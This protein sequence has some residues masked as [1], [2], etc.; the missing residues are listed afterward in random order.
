MADYAAGFGMGVLAGL[1]AAAITGASVED[2]FS[3]PEALALAWVIAWPIGSIVGV[4][5]VAR[6]RTG[7][8]L[9]WA[10]L[11][12]VVG[13]GVL[14]LPFWLRSDSETLRAVCGIAALLLAPA[15]ARWGIDIQR[16][17]TRERFTER[18]IESPA[19]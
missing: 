7:A 12:T 19:V 9:A 14:L 11:L 6:P 8:S 10:A 15:L 18:V 3:R 5:L 16:R 17:R 1:I 2:G 4:W 13:C